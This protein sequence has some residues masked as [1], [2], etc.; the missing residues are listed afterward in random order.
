[1]FLAI[2]FLGWTAA[3]SGPSEPPGTNGVPVGADIQAKPLLGRE[4]LVLPEPGKTPLRPGRRV[5][6]GGA[7]VKTARSKKPLQMINPLAPARYGD[8]TENLAVDPVT[9]KA[10]GVTLFSISFR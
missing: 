10:R 7:V 8:G 5:T 3:R 6:Y 1:M 9:G 2:A 4:K